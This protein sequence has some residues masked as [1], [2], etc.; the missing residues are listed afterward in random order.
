M[1]ARET[2][3]KALEKS[4]CI[5][6]FNIPHLPMLKAVAQAVADEHAVAMIQV[7]RL[8]W[9]KF[10]AQ[11]LEAV[12]EE[13]GR[14]AVSGHTLLH[15]DHVPVI[16]EDG[17]RVDWLPILRRALGAGYQS[18]MLDGSRLPLPENIRASREAADLAHAHAA[19]CEAEL[20]SVMGHEGSGIGSSYEELFRSK[21]G[22]TDPD[23]ARR[24][25]R[26]SGCDWLSVAA[27]SVHGAI[28]ASVRLEKKPEA[29]LDT[30]HIA[31]LR[32][33]AG[34]PLVLHGGSGINRGCVREAIRAGIAKINVGTDIRQPYER[35]MQERNDVE[36][37]RQK[38]YEAVRA[39]ISGF[40]GLSGSRE[41]L[42]G[43]QTA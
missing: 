7:A 31:L 30:E 39:V 37:A 1:D 18:V 26:E 36:Y 35:A 33:A 13:Y 42:Q 38:T 6:A 17:L 25:A 4:L 2:V 41:A 22:F 24:F 5:P 9:V 10:E 12:A 21:K 3:L 23:E 16:D 8:E 29:R 14:H 27:G 32:K 28:A 20:G 11:S 15:L 40:L 43:G 34:V 19:G